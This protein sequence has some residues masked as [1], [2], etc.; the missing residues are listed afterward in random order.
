MKPATSGISTRLAATQGRRVQLVARTAAGASAELREYAGSIGAHYVA[1]PEAAS[2]MRFSAELVRALAS[3]SQGI[4][5]TFAGAY[6][7][8]LQAPDPAAAL[9][10]WLARHLAGTSH[11]LVIDRFDRAADPRIARFVA[12]VV[13]RAPGMS[14]IVAATSFSDLPIAAWLSRDI[15][16][17]PIEMTES[18]DA[19]A[20][21]VAD[22]AQVQS[23]EAA[24]DF[25]GA[26]EMLATLDR[27]AETL[28]LIERH[29][30]ALLESDGAYVLHDAI[31][32]LD[33]SVK[34]TSSI[35]LTLLAQ[36]AALEN[37]SDVAEAHFKSALAACGDELQR[38]RV[39]FWYAAE[40]LRHGRP[41]T[42]ELFETN[43]RQADIPARLRIASRSGLAAAYAMAV[44]PDEARTLATTTLD[45]ARAFGDD[46]LT[47]RVLHQAA[48]VALRGS[49]YT[50]AK[51]LA[52]ESLDLAEKAGVYETAAGALSVL[53]NVVLDV[54]EDLT[55]AA[56][57]LRRIADCGAKCGSVEKQLYGLAALYEI[58]VE[59]GNEAAAAAVQSDLQDFDV[60]FGARVTSEGILPAQVMQFAWQGEFERAHQI[61]KASG[62]QQLDAGRRALRWSEIA[63]YAAAARATNQ[64][65]R[66]IAA[67][68]RHLRL[69]PTA[70]VH[71]VRARV[72]LA[73][74]HLLLGLP[75][76]A[77][78]E[79]ASL[80]G[81]VP[82]G[83]GRLRAMVDFVRKLADWH[84]GAAD[85]AEL[86]GRL[87]TLRQCDLG[88]FARML[89]AL[90]ADLLAPE[91]ADPRKTRSA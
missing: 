64:S 91:L 41:E 87:E 63:M 71:G 2:F 37:R 50:E 69:T 31:A 4:G 11:T 80:N 35:V 76:E 83:R 15:A 88:G 40:L 53:Y 19:T 27:K 74:T 68:R 46:A 1:L 34:A 89:E 54:D 13:E 36:S 18:A 52:A 66:A 77:R 48:F 78:T 17:P 47:A 6:T 60:T 65:Q 51:D 29:G 49:R 25:A 16:E 57:L 45:L 8:S 86:L 10:T 12:E 55:G 85:H 81:N 20:T 62:D 44:R 61:L 75:Q 59:R 73:L 82:T 42:I 58:E 39:R 24:G 38:A 28:A 5:R 22:L 79:M 23:L 84:L 70:S 30:F 9:A 33:D 7:R 3:S 56:E 67:T 90:P 32:R 43:D 21:P 14:L 72:H 26:L